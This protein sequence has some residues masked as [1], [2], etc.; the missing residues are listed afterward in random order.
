MSFYS[1]STLIEGYL[2]MS[3][4]ISLFMVALVKYL[5][6]LLV[7]SLLPNYGCPTEL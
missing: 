1:V 4:C 3:K 2:L 6:P 5:I 7:S